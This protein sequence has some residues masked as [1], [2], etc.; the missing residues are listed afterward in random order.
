MRV[1]SSLD[2]DTRWPARDL[3]WYQSPRMRRL[4]LLC[5]PVLL[6]FATSSLHAQ[7]QSPPQHSLRQ[8]EPA[9]GTN[10]KRAIVMG[11]IVPYDKRYAELTPEQQA[12]VKALYEQ[13]G[14]DDEPP[15]PA[16]G[17][18]PIYKAVAAAQQKL[19][20]TGSL[21]MAVQVNSQGEAT[22]VEV[23]RSPDPRMVQ[24]VAAVLMLQKYKPALCSGSPCT[25]QFPV[26]MEFR[27]A[28]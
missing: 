19:Q 12:A 11:G 20:V 15:F 13:I 25:M 27:R 14:P 5:L 18:A 9:T 6:S 2:S 21:T 26:R 3:L 1:D 16:A 7:D 24:F 8:D 22:S 23:L 10:I 28:P 17:L 4:P